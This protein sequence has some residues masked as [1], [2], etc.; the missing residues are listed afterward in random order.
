MGKPVLGPQYVQGFGPQGLM[1]RIG[2][3]RGFGSSVFLANPCE[4]LIAVHVLEPTIRVVGSDF[5]VFG[6]MQYYTKW[7]VADAIIHVV[8]GG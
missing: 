1:G 3:Q 8:V 2:G 7:M 4:R 5:L 6:A